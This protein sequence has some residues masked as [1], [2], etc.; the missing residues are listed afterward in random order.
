MPPTCPTDEQCLAGADHCFTV[1]SPTDCD[2]SDCSGS[3]TLEWVEACKW[4][5]LGGA[6]FCGASI[7]CIA[8]YWVLEI[9]KG[10]DCVWK[11]Q[12]T[13]AGDTPA[14]I[15]TLDSGSCNACDATVT[16]SAC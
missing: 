7:E 11:L 5:G 1:T 8:G 16:V 4:E 13:G 10:E 6:D 3:Y 12:G 9:E 14:G 15:Y 2:G